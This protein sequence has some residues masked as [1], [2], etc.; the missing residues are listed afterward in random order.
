MRL[1]IPLVLTSSAIVTSALPT[2]ESYDV[3]AEHRSLVSRQNTPRSGNFASWIAFGESFSAGPGAGETVPGE[4]SGCFQRTG[5]YPWQLSQ[6]AEFN[7]AHDS[8]KLVFASC[9]GA[10]TS[11]V[12]ARL[13]SVIVDSMTANNAVD[14]PKA[15]AF[16]QQWCEYWTGHHFRWGQ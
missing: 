3:G 14:T 11:D 10:T 6:D 9:S 12:S 7:S 2:S 4:P 5:A 1:D 15:S 16:S 8:P 13:S